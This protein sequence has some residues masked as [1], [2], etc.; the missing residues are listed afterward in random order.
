M[1]DETKEYVA[2]K[3]LSVEAAR[4]FLE[5]LKNMNIYPPDYTFNSHNGDLCFA[6]LTVL[7]T[8][9]LHMGY[10]VDKYA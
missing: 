4:D 3:L 5:Y 6:T 10:K 8:D 2:R 7:D 9:V 1:K